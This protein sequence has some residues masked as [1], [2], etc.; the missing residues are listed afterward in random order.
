MAN[1]KSNTGA[2]DVGAMYQ[3]G[4]SG[5]AAS[6]KK[7]ASSETSI[8]GQIGRYALGYYMKAADN[9]RDS[10]KEDSQ[11]FALLLMLILLLQ[12]FKK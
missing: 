9:L 5:T 8:I 7:A 10:R 6:A 1:E 3:I 4:A 11:I 2:L 12:T